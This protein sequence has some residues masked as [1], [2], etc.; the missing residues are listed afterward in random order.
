MKTGPHTL[1]T[2]QATGRLGPITGAGSF[3]TGGRL[4]VLWISRPGP[5][6][7][8]GLLLIAFSDLK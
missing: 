6:D 1:N 8:P 7:L 2:C 3:Q 5:R 4:D